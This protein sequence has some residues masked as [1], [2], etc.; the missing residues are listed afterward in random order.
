MSAPWE[1]VVFAFDLAS[2][3]G[4]AEGT[5]G[6]VPSFGSVRFAP[7]GSPQHDIAAGAIK[8]VATRFKAD[9]PR[10]FV[11]EAPELFRLRSGKA[12]RATIEVLFGL[13]FAVS[14]AAKLCGVQDI[15]EASPNDVR[16]WFLGTKKRLKREEAKRAVVAECHRR[17]WRVENDDEAD[18]CAIWAYVCA[19]KVPALRDAAASAP[20]FCETMK[21]RTARHEAREHEEIPA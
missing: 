19:V 16:A 10:C 5:P 6:G 7:P 21:K 2:R 9:P 1:G 15:Q 13:P 18:A 4:Y 14:G 8:W 11:F 20:L 3:A 17:G 12:T